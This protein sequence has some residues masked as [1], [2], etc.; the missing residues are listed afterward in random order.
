MKTVFS[1]G[2]RVERA[3]YGDYDPGV[4]VERRARSAEGCEVLKKRGMEK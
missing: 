3:G 1:I 4:C 2:L